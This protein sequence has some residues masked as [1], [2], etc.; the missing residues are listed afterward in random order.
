M[1]AQLGPWAA[2]HA[3]RDWVAACDDAARCAALS[4]RACG[5]RLD[6][7]RE[8]LDP[9]DLARLLAWAEQA[10]IVGQRAA[11][12]AGERVNRSEDRPVIHGPLRSPDRAPAALREELAA[13][14]AR[15]LALQDEIERDFPGHALLHIGIGGS[16]LGPRLAAEVAG[17]QPRRALHF[18]N[19]L[20]DAT[21]QST[22]ARLDPARTLVCVVSKSFG[23]AET[24]ALY[25]RVADWLRAGGVDPASA[26]VAVTANPERAQ[27]EAGIPG[28]RVAPV[29]PGVGGRYS[30]W[31]AVSFSLALAYGA[32]ARA[33]LRAGAAAM[34]KHFLDSPLAQNLPVLG[35]L[36]GLWQ[37]NGQGLATRIVV[38][39]ADRLRLLPEYLQQLEMESN[40]KRVDPQGRPLGHRTAPATFGGVGSCVQHAFFQLLHQSEDVHPVEFV[41]PARVPGVAPDLQRTLLSHALAQACALTRG[42]PVEGADE[43]RLCPG[44]RPSSLIGLAQLDLWHLGAL[45]AYYEH[46]TAVQGW[47]WGLNSYDQFGVEIGKQ[48][49]GEVEAALQGEG[50]Y[51]DAACAAAAQALRPD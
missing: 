49:A 50:A 37:R 16:D 39:Y 10:D 18:L 4:F 11:Q 14:E 21:L 42:R 25:A 31:S 26:S 27:Q 30:L 29:H 33:E 15:L 7:A 1:L 9:A 38:P 17:P 2:A 12:W 3:G 48:I 45:L 6:L 19:N 23:T 34:D 51:P 40:G 24:R 32:Q 43:S 46:R 41:L 47:L 5:L 13:Q 44:S 22:L 28:D 20:D 35:A 8:Q 36:A